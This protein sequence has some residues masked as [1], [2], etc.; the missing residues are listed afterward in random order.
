M[1]TEFIDSFFKIDLGM[2]WQLWIPKQWCQSCICARGNLQQAWVTA[3]RK[4]RFILQ[5]KEDSGAICIFYKI[6]ILKRKVETLKHLFM[7]TRVSFPRKPHVLP[8]VSL[9]PNP[10]AHALQRVKWYIRLKW[11]KTYI[12]L[13]HDWHLHISNMLYYQPLFV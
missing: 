9:L 12:P 4:K 8:R 11:Y 3:A 2:F 6:R 13:L 1:T 10:A 7:Q 5:K